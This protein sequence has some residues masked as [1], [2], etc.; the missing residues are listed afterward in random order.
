MNWRALVPY[1]LGIWGVA[2]VLQLV[3]LLRAQEGV[4]AALLLRDWAASATA[5]SL[6]L[7]ADE[8]RR[9]D[10]IPGWGFAVVLL[11][12]LAGLVVL[13]RPATDG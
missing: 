1:L 10:L 9:V 7:I 2:A 6:V 13:L 12:A 11:A 3:R 4:P 5:V 8:A